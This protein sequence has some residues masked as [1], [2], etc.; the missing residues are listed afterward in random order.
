MPSF[1][2]WLLPVL[3][4]AVWSLW[5][6]AAIAELRA[7]EI[8]RGTP[9]EQRGGV[10]ILPVI[11]FFPLCFWGVARL[12]DIWLSPWG[13]VVVGVLHLVLAAAMAFTFVRDL[14]YCLRH[15]RAS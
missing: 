15:E 2:P 14:R 4:F 5:A 7:K 11:P 6:F 8:R 13:T 3:L 12:T 10:S 9:K 1:P